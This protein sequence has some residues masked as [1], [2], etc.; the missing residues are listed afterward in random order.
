MESQCVGLAEALGLVPAVKRVSL[1]QPWRSFSP[2]LR[3]GLAC[4]FKEPFAPPW[5]E[6]LIASGRL[7]VAASLHVKAQATRAG[8]ACFTIQIQ[9][10]VI[11]PR[12]FD[13]VVTPLHDGLEGAN[14]ISTLG[15]LHRVAPEKL[16]QGAADLRARV[17]GLEGPYIGVLI[18][19]ANGAYRLGR[20]EILN[21][22]AQLRTIAQTAKAS[23]LVTPSRRTGEAN[24]ALLRQALN[25]APAFVWDGEGA[26]PY[27]GIL[28][29]SR[30]LVVT[31]D[32]VNMITEACASGK[33]VY[34]FDLPGGGSAKS[35]R[36]HTAIIAGNHAR[37]FAVPLEPY[38]VQPLREMQRVA[39]E[40]EHRLDD[41]RSAR[42]AQH[43]HRKDAKARRSR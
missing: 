20:E 27:F 43:S 21:L 39:A 2:Y 22:A 23:L 19:G 40:I 36:F 28:G 42:D 13:L 29:L 30:A 5:P 16:V 1:R 10:P 7:S 25:G 34:I 4:A 37:K 38:A 35:S 33:P 9:D 11:S 17:A 3:A 41:R 12:H 18:G 6:L 31:A 26:N 24:I 15:A 14:V 8:K 32:S